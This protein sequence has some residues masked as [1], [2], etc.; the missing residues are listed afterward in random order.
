MFRHNLL[1]IFRN[2]KRFKSTFL[3]NLIGLSTGLTCTLLIYLWVADELNVDKFHEKDSQLFQVMES[4]QHS[5]SIRSTNSTPWLLAEALTAEMPE[6]EYA[7]VA[8]PSYWSNNLTLTFGE[9]NTKATGLYVGKDYFN[10]FSYEL[11]Q[12]NKN[13]V[14]SDKGSIVISE[15]VAMNLFNSTENV[16]GKTIE[17]QHEREYIVSGVFKDI[18]SNSS[19]KFDFAL[20]VDVLKELQ[21]GVFKWENSGPNT[22]LVLKQGTDIK[23][24]NDKIAGFIKTK[25]KDTHRTLYLSKYSEN[26]LYNPIAYGLSDGGRIEY[27]TLFGTVALFILAIA[28][29]NFMNLSTAKASR[30]IK[31]IGVKKAVGAGRKTL[32]VQYLGESLVITFI[33]LLTAIFIADLFL[34]QFNSITGKQLTLQADLNFILAILSI[35]IVTGLIAGSYPALYLSAFKPAIVLRG[36]LHSSLGELWARKGLVIFQFSISV[37]FIVS[38]MVVYKQIEYV[39]NKNLGYNKDNVVYFEKEGRIKENPETFLTEVEKI[40]GIVKASSIAQSMVGGGNT[41]YIE[42]EG[43]DPDVRIPFAIRPVNFGVIEMLNLE[44]RAGRTFSR[45]RQDTMKVI[46]NEAGIEAMGLKDPIGKTIKLGPYECEIIG[47][48]KN[49]HYESLHVNVGPLFFILAPAYTEKIIVKLEG[50]QVPETLTRLQNFYLQYNPGFVFEYEFLDQDYQSQYASEQRVATLSKYFSGIAIVISCLGLFGLAAFTAERRL[51]EIGIRKVLG[52][53]EFG[54][55]YLLSTDFT[56]MVVAAVA[57]G[58]PVSYLLIKNWLDGFAFKIPLQWWYFLSAG[59][60]ALVIAWLTVGLQTI[61]AARM[62]PTK[63]LNNE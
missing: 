58:L 42:W 51:K 30:R 9:K 54:I 17:F 29:I 14:L 41:S 16:L 15:N 47:I 10:I 35:T 33:S 50:G 7:S 21:P 48:V 39:Q 56:K 55:V 28:C 20:S 60:I 8:T 53:S 19:T 46:F 37:I 62:N 44:L 63:C 18:P 38:V 31:E 40:P 27:I 5:G 25:S 22:F 32:I 2:F 59:V 4:Q 13:Q 61:K 12:G 45:E 43:K 52:S 24:F 6:I 49:F 23:A 3:I 1:L 34:P 57:I 26:Y 36:K 11:L